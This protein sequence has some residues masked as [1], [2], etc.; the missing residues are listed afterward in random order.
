MSL[1]STQGSSNNL[2]N[3]ENNSSEIP[4][5]N[6]L[7]KIPIENNS[8]TTTIERNEE[9]KSLVIAIERNEDNKSPVT[10]IERS[11]ENKSPVIPIENEHESNSS[12][13]SIQ[14]QEEKQ[15]NTE[16]KSTNSRI[17]SPKIT[18]SQSHSPKPT[19]RSQSPKT[20][21]IIINER[22]PSPITRHR[23]IRKEKLI[24][25]NQ[26]RTRSNSPGK[27]FSYLAPDRLNL[28][29][30]KQQRRQLAKQE[31]DDR[32]YHENRQKLERL[33]RIAKEPSSY[34][35]IHIEQERLRERHTI[36]YRRKILKNHIP[37]LRE[38]LYIVHR[39]ANVK[40][41]YDIDKMNNDYTRHTS[42]LKQDAANRKKAR[43]TAAQRPF[44]LPKINVK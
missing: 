40:G 5:E 4:I 44:I 38:N 32:I 27:K 21:N 2:R 14:N 41:V 18:R 10:A 13:A 16:T 29:H 19:E 37:I 26:Q 8:S 25:T 42:I 34:P 1:H 24:S 30:W 11:E 35:S 3:D 43:E 31:E 28:R 17:S 36:D 7:S 6:N 23:V 9:N 12:E 22:P 20:M 15:L 33:A 39:L